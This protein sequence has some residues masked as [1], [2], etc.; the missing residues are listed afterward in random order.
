MLVDRSK[1]LLMASALAAGSVAC[2]REPFGRAPAP[3]APAVAAPAPAPAATGPI[4]V[5]IVEPAPVGAASCDDSQ[6]VP[7]ECPS[8]GP[9]DEGVCPDLIQKRCTEYK[10]AMKP[11]V[12]AQAVACLRALKGNERCDPSRIGQCG[13]QA[14]MSACQEPSRPKKGEYRA[15]QGTQPASVTI[16]PDASPETS[17][18]AAACNGILKAC[19]ERPLSPSQADCRQTLAGL[20]EA[21]RASMVECVTQHCTDRGLI[22]CEAAPKLVSARATN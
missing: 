6:G 5:D 17:P 10:T 14:L 21:G 9:S 18:V 2:D 16:T 22:G 7:E 15:A 11:R 12:A 8:V 4:A 20:T 3:P 19:G 1:F 13:H